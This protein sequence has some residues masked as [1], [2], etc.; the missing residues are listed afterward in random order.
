[1]KNRISLIH[2]KNQG[3]SQSVTGWCRCGKS[4]VMDTNVECLSCGEVEALGYF[5]LSDMRYDDRSVYTERVST[6]VL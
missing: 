5:Q 1:M 4:G 3:K 2:V 6:T